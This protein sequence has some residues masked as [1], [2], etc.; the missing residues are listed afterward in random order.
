MF[1]IIFRLT[2]EWVLRSTTNA[3][4]VEDDVLSQ[5]FELYASDEEDS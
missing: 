4:D 1:F 2:L 3:N 5:L